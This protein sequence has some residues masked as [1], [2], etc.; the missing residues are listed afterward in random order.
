MA[1][2][3]DRSEHVLRIDEPEGMDEIDRVAA[4]AAERIPADA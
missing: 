3:R 2:V 4:A 1:P